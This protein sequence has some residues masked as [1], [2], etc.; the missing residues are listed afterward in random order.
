[1]WVASEPGCGSTFSFTLPLYS[2]AKLLTPVIIHQGR[3]R[4]SI[5][6]VRV[7]LR[8]RAN[9]PHAKWKAACTR[10]LELLERCVY[11]DKDLV[12]P[13][14]TT[15]G[16]AQSLFVVASTDL[17][18]AEIMMTRI[19]GQLGNLAELASAG[20]FDISVSPVPLPDPADG[21]SLQ[22]RVQ[23]VADRVTEMARAVAVPPMNSTRDKDEERKSN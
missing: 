15:S 22:H 3:M 18:R 2:L 5:V 7:D 8:P 13:P 14:L 6:L 10:S 9:P 23:A 20:Q 19:R 1:M 4:E 16:P 17:V 12:L 11:L 21:Q